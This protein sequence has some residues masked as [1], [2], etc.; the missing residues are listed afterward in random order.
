MILGSHSLCP[1]SGTVI[2]F[3]DQNGKI[4]GGPEEPLDMSTS[5]HFLHSSNFYPRGGSNS[6]TA[7]APEWI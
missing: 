6:L 2:G 4:A 7:G 1:E 3:S 5:S